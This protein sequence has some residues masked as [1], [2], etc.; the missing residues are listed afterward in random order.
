MKAFEPAIIVTRPTGQAR[1][2]TEL[3][4]AATKA[5]NSSVR[6]M[7]LPLL[8]IIP[9]NDLVLLTQLRTALQR[10]TLIIFVS[11]NAIECAMR[12]VDDANSSWE[13]LV[14][15][16]VRIGVVGQSSQEALIRHGLAE[17]SIL[18]P[19]QDESDSEGLWKVLQTN[20]SAWP[21]ESVLIIKGEGG[22]ETLI[23][24]LRSVSAGLEILSIYSRVPLDLASPL[25]QSCAELDPRHTLWTLTSSEAVR[26]L[27]ERCKEVSRIPRL[28][29]ESSSALCSHANIA[30]A[31]QQ[32]G[33][34]N[35]SVCE[36][37]DESIS[38]SAAAW[39][40]EQVKRFP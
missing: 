5:V 2:L 18:V 16:G 17:E 27:G 7:S 30:H 21:K 19:A 14:N 12:A 39:L 33:F 32:I 36:P 6:I 3:I 26:H 15:P 10:A 29:I 1:R 40:A 8:T 11:P 38:H 20:I 35:I 9:K 28:A 25:W 4:E 23:E 24:Q 22:R 31:A 37:R 13:Q 34:K